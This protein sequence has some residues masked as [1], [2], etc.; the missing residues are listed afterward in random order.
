LGKQ[1][2]EASYALS[3]LFQLYR[4]AGVV[5]VP[6]PLIRGLFSAMDEPGVQ[7]PEDEDTGR[8]FGHILVLH[9][10]EVSK[11]GPDRVTERGKRFHYRLG[12][13]MEHALPSS[14]S[15]TVSKVWYLRAASPQL[16][17]VRRSYGLPSMPTETGF[18][19]LVALK[20]RGVL[21]ETSIS[22]TVPH[23]GLFRLASRIG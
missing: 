21:G 8:L 18:F 12:G 19:C 14:V 22:K 16:Q 9:R 10:D 2:S 5:A 11:I 20:K 15:K 7:L 4:G 3:G 1:A 17:A 23:G 13:L 6:A